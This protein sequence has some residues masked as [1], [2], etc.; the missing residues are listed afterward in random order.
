MRLAGFI[1]SAVRRLKALY[2]EAEA[3]NI[4]LLL[5]CDR[6][7]VTP[8]T[9]VIEP[10]TEVPEEDRPGL[11]DDLR[12]LCEAEPLQYVLGWTEF[13]GR[14]F[15]TDRR[16]LIPRAETELLVEEAVRMAADIP[17]DGP[18]RI[19]DLC[20]GSGCIAWSLAYELP[21]AVVT[22]SDLSEEA[23]ALARS[24]FR[25]L[26]RQVVRPVFIP[27]DILDPGSAFPACDLLT[28]NPPYI[29]PAERPLM[30]S[31]VLDWEPE[32][33]LFAPETDPLS[34]H[35]ALAGWAVKLLTPG[36]GGIVEINEDL[37]EASL[38]VFRAAGLRDC[39]LVEDFAGKPRF[40]RFRK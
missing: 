25:R 11:E 38:A 31:N 27:G 34:F 10:E 17:S 7:G 33:A 19:L 9:H 18:L 20:T 15:K 5:V 39:A 12:R 13:R 29:T 26:P 37:G 14:V 8:Y 23:L 28:A 35:R 21:G 36:G 16:A 4:V 2:P 24:Q 40:V 6:L 3:R 22:A 30:R 1:R 32:M